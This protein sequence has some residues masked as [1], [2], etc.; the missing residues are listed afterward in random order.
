MTRVDGSRAC[1]D[2]GMHQ[3]K[4]QLVPGVIGFAPATDAVYL[5]HI[6]RG[7]SSIGG[8]GVNTL[9][10][11]YATLDTDEF[12]ARDDAGRSERAHAM[13]RDAADSLRAGGADFLVVTSNTG[14]IILEEIDHSG[15]LP[16]ESI[17]D[18]VLATAAARGHERVGLLSTRRTADSRRYEDAG[19]GVGVEVL[20]PRSELVDRVTSMI[21]REA[22]RGIQT[23]EGLSMLREAVSE[24]AARGADAIV[25]GCT[26]L[27]LFGVEAI[28]GG[29]LPVLDSTVEHALAAAR[30]ARHGF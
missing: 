15:L 4:Q 3:E 8:G 17:F 23:N 24:L 18:A 26:D 20:V 1:Q 12:F 22:I 5:Q 7:D 10:L 11:L 25:L 9:R 13:I 2:Q 19:V 28:G 30:R 21:D 29:V 16:R 6:Q 14:S 27:M